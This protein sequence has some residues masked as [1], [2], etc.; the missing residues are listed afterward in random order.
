MYP[1]SFDLIKG[2][3]YFASAANEAKEKEHIRYCNTACILLGASIIESM[4]NEWISFRETMGP[5]NWRKHIKKEYWQTLNSIQKNISVRDK[6]NLFASVIGG[7]LWDSSKE[8]FQSY[9][10]ILSLRNELV[11]YK[12]KFL[13]HGE[14][15][16]NKL[17]E[18]FVKHSVGEKEP[19][20]IDDI[21]SWITDLL[22]SPSLGLWVKEKVNYSELLDKMHK[23][24]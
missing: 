17:K 16:V 19:K 12:G 23:E 14:V 8:P 24:S 18:L 4:L 5:D 9:E 1:F 13:R 7:E 21:S 3:H 2:C 10:V 22:E 15:P 20:D 6:W 11:H